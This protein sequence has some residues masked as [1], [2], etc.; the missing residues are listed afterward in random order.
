MPTGDNAIIHR[1][2]LLA[3][4]G[5]HNGPPRIWVQINVLQIIPCAVAPLLPLPKTG[6][7][8]KLFLSIVIL[9]WESFG[10]FKKFFI[11][12]LFFF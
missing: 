2:I 5:N 1:K 11:N 10:E 4:S 7:G 6:P 9:I 8:T 12:N 3:H